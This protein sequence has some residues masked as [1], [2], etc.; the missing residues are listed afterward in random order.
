M[1]PN[2]EVR[3]VINIDQSGFEQETPERKANNKL[4]PSHQ[5]LTEP[6]AAGCV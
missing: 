1:L 4:R 5:A 6:Q 3:Y 2:Y